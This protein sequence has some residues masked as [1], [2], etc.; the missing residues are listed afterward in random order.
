MSREDLHSTTL[1]KC[2]TVLEALSRSSR[3]LTYTDILDR[4]GLPKSTGYRLISILANE[5]LVHFDAENRTYRIGYR[6]LELAAQGL[7]SFD[8]RDI[9]APVLRAVGEATQE[10][11]LL[12]VRDGDEIVYIDRVE[13]TRSVR[14]S[15]AVGNRAPLY[16]TG[17]G[18]A[19]LA[20]LPRGARFDLYA[21][22]RFHR[23][24][25]NT[26]MTADVLETELER[27]RERGFAYDD[28]EHQ[29]DIRCVAAPI[30]G[31]QGEPVGAV[32]ISAP[33]SRADHK[34]LDA[35]TPLV[36]DAASRIS[37]EIGGTGA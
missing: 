3:P 31:R 36:R 7:N 21:T 30:L 5:R 1:K 23:F 26:I 32:S 10:N 27:I 22:M 20:F 8:L 17:L 34:S 4:T 18:K 15:T 2:L 9:A 19:I 24:T 12:A 25:T 35:W 33:S 37:R 11:V 16:C 14:S 6:L 28:T 13:S 29:P